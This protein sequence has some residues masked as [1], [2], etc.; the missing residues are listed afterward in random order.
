V[1]L[2]ALAQP[3]IEGGRF[4]LVDYLPTYAGVLFVITLIWAGAPGSDLDF[5]RAWRTAADLN[6]GE[7]VLLAV[8]VTLLAVLGHPLQ[9]ATV[10]LLEGEWP[11]WLGSLAALSRGHQR[12]RRAQL[13]AHEELP[14]DPAEPITEVQVQA[15]G[16]AGTR[17]RR[18]YPPADVLRPTALGNVLAA[19]E[20]QAGE[21]YGLDAA[22]AWP[23]LYPVLGEQVRVITDDRRDTLDST[24]R[25]SATLAASAIVSAALLARSGWWLLLALV[26]LAVARIAYIGAVHAAAAYGE[27]VRAAFDLHHFDLIAALHIPL[28]KDLSSERIL[29]T[30]FCDFWRQGVPIITSYDHPEQKP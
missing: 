19:V 12:R 13:A 22:V 4:L 24:A 14:E 20:T 3:S 23:R 9:L 28:P 16:L 15:A 29:N 2:D 5:D 17:L 27:A 10:R 21:P 11:A 1:K 25:L 30:Q 26:P 18:L 8:A 7:L 6:I